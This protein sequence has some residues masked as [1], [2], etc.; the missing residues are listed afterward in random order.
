MKNTHKIVASLAGVV[1]LIAAAAFLAYELTMMRVAMVR[2][3][4]AAPIFRMNRSAAPPIALVVLTRQIPRLTQAV[5][6]AAT[7]VVMV[8]VVA[9]EAISR[10]CLPAC[11]SAA[12]NAKPLTRN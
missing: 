2:R 8:E 12:L 3:A 5:M 7:A 4:I 9:A 6:E 11:N 10:A 1:L